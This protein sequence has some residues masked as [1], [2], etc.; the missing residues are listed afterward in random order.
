VS[1]Y[2]FI[3]VE[4]GGLSHRTHSLLSFGAV[5]WEDGVLLNDR[6]WKIQDDPYR[7]SAG[8]LAINKIDLIAHHSKAVTKAQA[9]S[10]IWEY[11]S[12]HPNMGQTTPLRLAGWNVP[13]DRD[14]LRQLFIDVDGDDVR[15]ER[16][17]SHRLLDLMSVCRALSDSGLVSH[18]IRN[19]DEG[20][21]YFGVEP[22]E[23]MRHTA[24]GDTIAQAEMYTKIVELLAA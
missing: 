8:A 2:L 17:F 14:F 1:K 16:V 11:A 13:F 21:G 22:H 19:S 6:E 7:V 20:Y 23:S 4:T 12:L 5:L 18:D 3:D 9:V 24:I 15:F 10:Q